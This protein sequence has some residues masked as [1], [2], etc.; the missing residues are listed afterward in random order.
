MGKRH[1]AVRLSPTFMKSAGDLC[2]SRSMVL[3]NV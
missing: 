2:R 1:A 3:P